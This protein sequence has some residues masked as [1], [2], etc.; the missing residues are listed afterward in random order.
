MLKWTAMKDRLT[1]RK[2]KMLMENIT[3]YQVLCRT[4]KNGK[5]CNFQVELEIYKTT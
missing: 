3:E 5:F 2:N 4:Q 1:R